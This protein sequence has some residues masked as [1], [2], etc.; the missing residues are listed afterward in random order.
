MNI[1]FQGVTRYTAAN[2]QQLAQEL[3]FEP[4]M[5]QAAAMRQVP[6]GQLEAI[7]L[8]GKDFDVF[9]KDAIGVEVPDTLK[10]MDAT[11]AFGAIQTDPQYAG[12]KARFDEL[13][14]GMHPMASAQYMD[15]KVY[16]YYGGRKALGQDAYGNP[17][18]EKNLNIT[19]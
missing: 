6:G 8:D 9:M 4:K 13:D 3:G 1:Q 14:N 12:L 19:A 18:Q 15:S 5:G 7:V 17:L 2:E 11:E 10:G 16:E